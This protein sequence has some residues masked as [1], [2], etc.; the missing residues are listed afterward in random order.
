MNPVILA[1]L[2]NLCLKATQN[3]AGT[4][5][6]YKPVSPFC[7]NKVQKINEETKLNT[8]ESFPE[9]IFKI[10]EKFQPTRK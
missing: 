6:Y 10:Y 5:T 1:H 2:N 9:S 8:S 3:T 7:T 4:N